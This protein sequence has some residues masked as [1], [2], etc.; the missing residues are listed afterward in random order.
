MQE[1]GFEF[2][3]PKAP[4]V[5]ITSQEALLNLSKKP[6]LKRGH[7]Q[8]RGLSN[9]VLH[10]TGRPIGL[11]ERLVPMKL[12]TLF[13]WRR[14]HGLKALLFAGRSSP[15]A[16]S[17]HACAA[18]CC[19]RLSFCKGLSE[20]LLGWVWLVSHFCFCMEGSSCKP[21]LLSAN[22]VYPSR[23][24]GPTA[25]AHSRR[26]TIRPAGRISPAYIYIYTLY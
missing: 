17:M 9:R 26:L 15:I 7:L 19:A 24:T 2:Y 6:Q 5:R 4:E 18:T 12:I 13:W 10:S 11:D 3:V 22:S 23:R 14:L 20:H 16:S 8:L 25:S 1:M 21:V